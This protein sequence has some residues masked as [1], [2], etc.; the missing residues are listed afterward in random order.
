MWGKDTQSVEIAVISWPDGVE[1]A[2]I[3]GMGVYPNP[4]TDFINMSFVKEGL[5]TIEIVALDGKLIESKQ[6]NATTNE[7]VRVDVDGEK[8]MYIIKVK[9]NN[10]TAVRSLKVIKR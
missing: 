3:E 10:G 5:Y 8:G 6:I 2:V 4:F 7:C 1:D 9:N